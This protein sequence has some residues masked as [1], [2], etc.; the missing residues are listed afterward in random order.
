MMISNYLKYK[1]ETWRSDLDE[2]LI[3]PHYLYATLLALATIPSRS[4]EFPS[5]R[6]FTRAS[7]TF[8]SPLADLEEL[9][10]SSDTCGYKLP[11]ANVNVQPFKPLLRM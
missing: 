8:S 1:V 9:N 6:T 7:R 3:V 2:L 10:V 11:A 5:S 4:R